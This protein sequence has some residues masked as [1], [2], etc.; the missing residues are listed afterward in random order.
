MPCCRCKVG[1]CTH[2]RC[3]WASELCTN[4]ASAH[5]CNRASADSSSDLK[6]QHPQLCTEQHSPLVTS[7]RI[8]AGPQAGMLTEFFLVFS[9]RDSSVMPVLKIISVSVSIKFFSNH[10]G[11]VSVSV[12]KIISVSVKFFSNQFSFSISIYIISVTVFY[13]RMF[14]Q[15]TTVNIELMNQSIN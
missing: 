12:L 3:A 1:A 15:L 6:A 7:I 11:S 9:E 13:R 4:C 14:T 10:F 8:A 5:C 2:C